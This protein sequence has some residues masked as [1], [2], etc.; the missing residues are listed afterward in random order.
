MTRGEVEAK[1]LGLA[2]P[3][4]GEKTAANVIELVET[5]ENLESVAPLLA[6]LATAN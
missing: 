4:I 6:S 2:A 3:V 1:F 5:L